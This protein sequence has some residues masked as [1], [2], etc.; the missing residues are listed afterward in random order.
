MQSIFFTLLAAATAVSAFS[1]TNCGNGDYNNFGSS[2]NGGCHNW[3]ADLMSF[4]SDSG[5]TLTVYSGGNCS[6]DTYS[7]A[8]QHQCFA[9]PFEVQSIKCD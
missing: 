9:P 7:T 6:G 1:A 5:C 2:G 4:S 8:A 3:T